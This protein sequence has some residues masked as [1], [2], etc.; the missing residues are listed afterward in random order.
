MNFFAYLSLKTMFFMFFRT[1]ISILVSLIIFNA[2]SIS[3]VRVLTGL[4][5]AKFTE[6]GT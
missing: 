5:G 1:N 4:N 2:S 3:S 6:G